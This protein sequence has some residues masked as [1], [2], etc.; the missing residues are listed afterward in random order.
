MWLL[1]FVGIAQGAL[2]GERVLNSVVLLLVP[3]QRTE[4]KK[5]L[6]RFVLSAC[7][8]QLWTTVATLLG[9][10]LALLEM[11]LRNTFLVLGVLAVMIALTVLADNNSFMYVVL[12]N[13]YNNGV[14][15]LLH[16]LVIGP[17]KLAHSVLGMLLPLWNAATWLSGRVLLYIVLSVLQAAPDEI[18]RMLENISL[19]AAS[20]SFSMYNLAY[21][22][23][24]CVDWDAGTE[25]EGL[26]PFARTT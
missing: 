12:Y 4:T 10:G 19:F 11:L 2:V 17:L 9:F 22:V 21:R 1:V 15:Y 13:T 20:F 8:A 16:F 23:M 26:L 5:L 3:T 18:P 7:V 25:S 14:G 6:D 24:Q